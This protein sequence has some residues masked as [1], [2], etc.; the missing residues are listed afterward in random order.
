[1]WT[2]RLETE[3]WRILG[4]SSRGLSR[5]ATSGVS[6]NGA[7][8]RAGRR[9]TRSHGGGRIIGML[10]SAH[11]STNV[12]K[13]WVY[14][15]PHG[16]LIAKVWSN[17]EQSIWQKFCCQFVCGTL[18]VFVKEFSWFRFKPSSH[19]FPNGVRSWIRSECSGKSYWRE[20]ETRQG[21]LSLAFFE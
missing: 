12:M 1:M 10:R 11:C 16:S 4:G 17:S 8:W 7:L 21:S 15:E 3:W 19:H 2:V 6:K 14:C 18:R 5:D 20:A 9:W 13:Y